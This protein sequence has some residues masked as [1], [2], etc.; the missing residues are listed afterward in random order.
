MKK[1][2]DFAWHAFFL[3]LPFF[4]CCIAISFLLGVLVASPANAK[5]MTALIGAFA[6]VLALFGVIYGKTKDRELKESELLSS[7]EHQFYVSL[8]LSHHYFNSHITNCFFYEQAL[9]RHNFDLN[10][11]PDNL[12]LS[13]K[14]DMDKLKEHYYL[15]IFLQEKY[16]FC[17]KDCFIAF[18]EKI[19]TKMNTIELL[20]IDSRLVVWGDIYKA[21]SNGDKI[22]LNESIR[23]IMLVELRARYTTSVSNSNELLNVVSLIVKEIK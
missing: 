11:V 15:A 4:L 23:M 20:D 6:G 2:S 22:E 18:R 12:T 21:F 14:E 3:T 8:Q 16:C 13:L 9:I 5:Y 7:K 17:N 1:Q 10:L 19:D